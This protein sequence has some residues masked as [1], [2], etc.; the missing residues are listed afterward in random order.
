MNRFRLELIIGPMF[1]G[2]STELIRRISCCEAIGQSSLL[3]NH[4]FDTRTTNFVKTHNNQKKK[5]IKTNNLMKLIETREFEFANIIG[6][7]EAQFFPDL[8]EFILTIEHLS[9]RI[10]VAGLDGDYKRE[11][12]GQILECIPLCDKIDRLTGMDMVSRDGSCGLFTKRI[13][14]D[15]ES[16]VI[17]DSDKYLTVNRENYLRN[18]NNKNK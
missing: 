15:T 1:S 18:K 12:I 10:Y 14:N 7:D 9:K 5:A 17:G 13:V 2:K 16:I 6:I 11:P 8:K 3:V 4:T